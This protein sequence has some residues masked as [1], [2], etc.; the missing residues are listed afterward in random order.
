M[1][2]LLAARAT[3]SAGY[4]LELLTDYA[5]VRSQFGHKI[6]SY[7]AI[8]HKLANCFTSVEICRLALV[9]A[10]RASQHERAYS[11]AVAAANAGQLLRDVVRELHHGF[12]GI[13]FWDEH[14]LPRHFRRIHG[15]LTRL[16]GVQ[17]ARRD[18]AA[19]LLERGAVPDM[20]LTPAAD[21]FRAEVREWLAHNW[22]HAYPPETYALPVNHRKAR[23]DFSRKVAPRAGSASTGPR[24]TAD[25]DAR[26][27]NISPSRRRWLHAEA[28]VTFTTPRPT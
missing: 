4:G 7:Q 19:L 22:D 16:G 28:P 24:P 1:R 10:G 13:S 12:G 27:S 2:L 20:A 23:Q 11:A 17:Q 26:P 9:A 21:A 3:G 8:Q 5:K 6:G 18:V 14:E 25:R 15:D